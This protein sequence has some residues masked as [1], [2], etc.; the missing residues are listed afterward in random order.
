[1]FVTLKKYEKMESKYEGAHARVELLVQEVKE[2]RNEEKM[3]NEKFELKEKKAVAALEDRLAKKTIELEKSYN[4]R[5]HSFKE[6]QLAKQAESFETMTSGNYEKLKNE[7][8]KLH[9]DGNATTKYMQEMTKEILHTVGMT[10]TATT[11][12]ENK[13]L[14]VI[15]APKATRKKTTKKKK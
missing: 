10:H 2:L 5:L 4:D 14:E 7:L 9:S 12:T 6:T 3:A 1:M 8:A 13:R 15:E 11:S